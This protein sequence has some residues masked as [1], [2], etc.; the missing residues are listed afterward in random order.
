MAGL[1]HLRAGLALTLYRLASRTAKG[2]GRHSFRAD[3]EATGRH[4]GD[5]AWLAGATIAGAV[6]APFFLLWDLRA[7]P[8]STASLLLAFEAVFT[9]LWA[10]G[11]FKEHVASQVW[12]A[13][14]ALTA[15]D[16]LLGL[17]GS[18]DWG[19][20]LGALAVV[21]GCALWGL[22]N[23]LT[24]NITTL[25]PSRVAQLKGLA[26]GT[27]NLLLL[28]A[29]GESL[30]RWPWLLSA[31]VV[32][33]LSYGVG[34]VLYVRALRHLGSTR[35]GAYFAAGPFFAARSPRSNGVQ[36]RTTPA[37]AKRWQGSPEN[38][39]ELRSHLAMFQEADATLPETE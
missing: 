34:L 23:N 21:G 1:L 27:V 17:Q 19:I 22:D 13:L 29:I 3:A 14:L 10:A 2:R 6:A 33:G 4:L 24:R 36:G 26:A 7:T 30:P 11:L 25:K 5:W 16:V 15:G 35:T 8:A 12:W 28:L 20:S 18:R 32:G 31:L 39:H 38:Q 9:A 37:L